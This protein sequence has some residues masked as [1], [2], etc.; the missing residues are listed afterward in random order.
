MSATNMKGKI[1]NII[2]I[3]MYYSIKKIVI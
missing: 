3:N 1:I 2:Y